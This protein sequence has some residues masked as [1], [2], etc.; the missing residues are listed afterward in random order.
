MTWR[1][2]VVQGPFVVRCLGD[3][4]VESAHVGA[5]ICG[6]RHPALCA[7]HS[8][9]GH[10]WPWLWD[11]SP[12][13]WCSMGMVLHEQYAVWSMCISS[14]VCNCASI[15][16]SI[17]CRF[18]VHEEVVGTRAS[19]LSS[20]SSLA[21]SAAPHDDC[22]SAAAPHV[23]APWNNHNGV[24]SAKG[25]VA[26]NWLVGGTAT[27]NPVFCNQGGGAMVSNPMYVASGS[28][29]G[30]A[31]HSSAGSQVGCCSHQITVPQY[32]AGIPPLPNSAA[33]AQPSHLHAP[34][35][36][37]PSAEVNAAATVSSVADVSVGSA[38]ASG[39]R[40]PPGSSMH[41]SSSSAGV[42]SRSYV[43]LAPRTTAVTETAPMQAA[44]TRTAGA[45]AAAATAPS[46]PL[47]P[48]PIIH[49]STVLPPRQSGLRATFDD[50]ETMAPARHL[51]CS[52][53]GSST[54][55]YA[56]PAGGN[57]VAPSV[58]GLSMA[59]GVVPS[60]AGAPFGI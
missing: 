25:G 6:P 20:A 22:P 12:Y 34:A 31:T 36:V 19:S 10:R 56:T 38:L 15:C 11:S 58:S 17:P 47:S 3:F 32:P 27:M 7:V 44:V 1:A 43:L 50:I 30:R 9:A 18:V 13:A 5:G 41:S 24:G 49:P 54:A 37:A 59:A 35:T 16:V 57:S 4:A 55:A 46:V 39:P 52:S 40:M 2:R 28:A 45:A 23:A 33:G 42:A 48:P 26:I 53:A 14:S 8:N 29:G 21:R 51:S 60:A